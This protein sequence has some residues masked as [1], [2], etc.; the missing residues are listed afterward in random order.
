MSLIYLVDDDIAV[1]DACRFLLESL[2]YK[3]KVWHHGADF[4]AQANLYQPGVLLLDIRMPVLD[5]TQVYSQMRQLNST[6]AVI[7]LTAHGEV[8]QAVEQMKL[9]AVDFL[10][11]PVATA[12]LIAALQQGLVQSAQQVTRRQVQL[13]YDSLTPREQMIAQWVM[14]GLINR[15]IADV[16]CVSVR[17]V[18]VHRAKVMEKM[19][20]NSLAELVSMLNPTK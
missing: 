8:P 18:E 4:L 19:A 9:G 14:Q 10:Q 11:K 16:A 13:R 1:T 5:G 3:V 7:F 12:P 17:T 20:A 6:L 2:G 15:D